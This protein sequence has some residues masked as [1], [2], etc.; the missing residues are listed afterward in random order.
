M[1]D[2]TTPTMRQ[3]YMRIKTVFLMGYAA[4]LAL[5]IFWNISRPSGFNITILLIQCVPLL[6]FLPG[7]LQNHYRTY[8]WVCFIILFYFVKAVE[9]AFASTANFTDGIFI[10]LTVYLFVCAMMAS[11]W[12]QRMLYQH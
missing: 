10:G 5:F 12:A 7:I 6:A 4:L 2:A 3:K 9:G 1:T 8:S 11:R